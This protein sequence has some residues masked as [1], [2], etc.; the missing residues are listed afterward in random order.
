MFS[1]KS[2]PKSITI[3]LNNTQ[4]K[5]NTPESFVLLLNSFY[6]KFNLNGNELIRA[7]IYYIS[8]Q[9]RINVTVEEEYSRIFSLTNGG[10]YVF[11]MEIPSDK[12]D[13]SSYDELSKNYNE[14][15]NDNISVISG[16]YDSVPT[17]QNVI[18]KIIKK[19]AFFNMNVQE[20]LPLTDRTKKNVEFNSH[21]L[22]K[23]NNAQTK[24]N[25]ISKII[26]KEQ[27]TKI[28]GASKAISYEKL[29][30]F[31]GKNEKK[32]KISDFVGDK[33]AVDKLDFIFDEF[34]HALK[35]YLKE[36]ECQ[37]HA[38][39]SEKYH[40]N[41]NEILSLKQAI[42]CLEE[43]YVNLSSKRAESIKEINRNV[44][45]KNKSSTYNQTILQDIYKNSR[46]K[47]D[48]N[49]CFNSNTVLKSSNNYLYKKKLNIDAKN[50]NKYYINTQA[51]KKDFVENGNNFNSNKRDKLK[52]INKRNRVS[53]DNDLDSFQCYTFREPS[54]AMNKKFDLDLEESSI[55][56]SSDLDFNSKI[57]EV[58]NDSPSNKENINVN[59]G[60]SISNNG[61]NTINSLRT[62]NSN[63]NMITFDNKTNNENQQKNYTKY[64]KMGIP[65]L[66]LS[67]LNNANKEDINFSCLNKILSFT[68]NKQIESARINLKLKNT[69]TK[70]WPKGS[71]LHCDKNISSL[72][73][74]DVY[75]KSLRPNNETIN[76]LYF[77][78]I[79][80]LETGDYSFNLRFKC[81]E[82]CFGELVCIKIKIIDRKCE[83]ETEKF[84]QIFGIVKEEFKEEEVIEALD[85]YNNDQIKTFEYLLKSKN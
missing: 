78:R 36:R 31:K 46:T 68:F 72:L 54:K 21:I 50:M 32:S 38:E 73:C 13:I 11:I 63:K 69:G 59:Y 77:E 48:K 7:K 66:S 40:S 6:E 1:S 9:N 44:L 80:G 45:K 23:P 37:I 25:L 49:F 56:L 65:K 24:F 22:H 19:P 47:P 79:N 17:E 34:K 27:D 81:G 60:Y 4:H 39:I 15:N 61:L 3:E 28:K 55:S 75:L 84:R 8:G 20:K 71:C 2:R 26:K 33:I 64:T 82:K 14:N 29:S 43:K 52:L 42:K 76:S 10:D 53:I 85:K 30:E 74:E 51:D 57:T 67:S 18:G 5:I 62:L 12:N 16:V 58:K 35:S 83:S 41:H 70:T